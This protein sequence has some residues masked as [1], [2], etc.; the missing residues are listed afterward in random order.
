MNKKV[1]KWLKQEAKQLPMKADIRLGYKTVKEDKESKTKY[2]TT[3]PQSFIVDHYEVM[4]QIYLNEGKKGVLNY[5]AN[6]K[7][8][9]HLPTN[10][11]Q[12]L[13]QEAAELHG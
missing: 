3:T 1:S 4:K 10:D 13:S 8:D 5:I 6:V 12:K 7:T 9:I 11:T 2:V